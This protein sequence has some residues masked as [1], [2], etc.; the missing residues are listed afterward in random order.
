MS[1]TRSFYDACAYNKELRQSTSVLDYVLDPN[2]FYN[3]NPCRIELGTFGGN[4]VSLSKDNLVNVESDL[5]NQTRQLS[6][7]PERK[8]LP[9]CEGCDCNEGLPCGGDSCVDRVPRTDL[10]SC[11]I[12]NYAPRIDNVGYSVKYPGCPV[13]NM[14]SVDGQPMKYQPYMNPVQFTDA[15]SGVV[16]GVK[17]MCG[18]KENRY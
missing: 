4:N 14:T 18:V 16:D 5:R 17:K 7:C 12:I 15:I 6:R 10:P 2:K 3:C 9:E 1:F 11:N 13:E 8:Y